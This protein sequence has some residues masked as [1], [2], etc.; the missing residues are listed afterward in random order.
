MNEYDSYGS[1]LHL[2]SVQYESNQD[3]NDKN[4]KNG[5]VADQSNNSRSSGQS[6]DNA[7]NKKN[8]SQET[9]SNMTQQAK[10]Q[11]IQD[12]KELIKKVDIEQPTK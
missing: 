6:S 3:K 7:Q 5:I 11:Q 9:G 2:G 12:S 8:I 4:R 10:N 1:F